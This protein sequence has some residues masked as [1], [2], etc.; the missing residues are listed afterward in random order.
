MFRRSPF[1]P[2][3]RRQLHPIAGPPRE[4]AGRP[5]RHSASCWKCLVRRTSPAQGRRASRKDRRSQVP[6]QR[7]HRL[8]PK[9][10]GAGPH[11]SN[12]PPMHGRGRPVAGCRNAA[13]A[14][15]LGASRGW[16]ACSS[17]SAASP[18]RPAVAAARQGERDCRRR[19]A[20]D[21]RTAP[22]SSAANSP[23]GRVREVR[24][25]TPRP[26][27]GRRDVGRHHEHRRA[28]RPRLASRR[29]CSPHQAPW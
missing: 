4:G 28:R 26:A 16:G 23:P 1:P 7:P 5:R 2:R 10:A 21:R 25:G 22:W 29:A 19:S 11:G 12:L 6:L 15:L 8:R 20:A 27:H 13:G 3:Q 9:G 18:G 14:A 24:R 17:R